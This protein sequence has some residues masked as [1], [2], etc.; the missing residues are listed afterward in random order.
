M[1]SSFAIFRMNMGQT[2][3]LLVL[4][5]YLANELKAP[6]SFDDI[7][8]SKIVYAVSAFD[9]LLHDLIRVG[10]VEVFKGNRVATP[11]YLSEAISMATVQQLAPGSTPPPEIAF[12][13][14]VR[15]KLKLLSFQDPDK[16]SE[17]LS[18]IW[19][20][21]HKW[22]KISNALG[23]NNSEL[24]TRLKLIVSRRNSIVHEADLNPIDGKKIEITRS[25]A[26]DIVQ[27]LRAV[28]EEI[29]NQVR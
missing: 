19:A 14:A 25:E 24:R 27:L 6:V 5:D 22:Q 12:E 17:G 11:K 8:R 20:E 3:S 2:E 29:Y 16:V 23:M 28:G 13:E 15:S 7:L 10:M 9:K 18:L 4:Y 21:S 1:H 26:I